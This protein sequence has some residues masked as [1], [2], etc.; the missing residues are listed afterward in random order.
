MKATWIECDTCGHCVDFHTP[1]DGQPE[2]LS[3]AQHDIADTMAQ[4]IKEAK[5][6]RETKVAEP[7]SEEEPFNYDDGDS[8][9]FEFIQ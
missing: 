2:A 5:E 4:W 7:K 3:R 8:L 9:P 6:V 1:S